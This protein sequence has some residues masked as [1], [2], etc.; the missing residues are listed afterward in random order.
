MTRDAADRGRINGLEGVVTTG[1]AFRTTTFNITFDFGVSGGRASALFGFQRPLFFGA[2]DLAQVVDA[3]I[4]LDG[5]TSLHEF[6]DGDGGQQS[7]DCDHDHDFNKR[8]A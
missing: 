5:G 3:S 1:W 8:E 7:D 2:V 6:R 4:F